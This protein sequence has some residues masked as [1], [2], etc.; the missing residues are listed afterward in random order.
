MGRKGLRCD[1]MVDWEDIA[2]LASK[3]LPW[4]WRMKP[5]T[6]WEGHRRIPST[7]ASRVKNKRM[8]GQWE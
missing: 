1:Y 7:R 4:H 3:R 6:T 5:G 2:W 8:R